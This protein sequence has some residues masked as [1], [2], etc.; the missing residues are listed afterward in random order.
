MIQICKKD[1]EKVFEAIRTGQIDAAEMSFPNLT[2]D[3]IL[4][5]K[6]QGLTDL[7]PLP[8]QTSAVTTNIF[9]WVSFCALPLPPNLNA[10]PAL[11]MSLLQPQKRGSCPNYIP[12]NLIHH[13]YPHCICIY[14]IKI[15]HCM[16]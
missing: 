12:L 6:K 9:L 16:I 15:N 11:R 7:L 3:I 4:T 14:H 2:G 5:M 13:G 1:K 8:S 10:R